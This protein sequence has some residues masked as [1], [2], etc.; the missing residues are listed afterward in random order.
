MRGYGVG[1]ADEPLT[2][3]AVEVIRQ[4][5]ARS[6]RPSGPSGA[7][8]DFVLEDR[9]ARQGLNIGRFV[10][11]DEFRQL[12]LS[13]WEV[14]SGPPRFS[15]VEVHAVHGQRAA[16]ISS[17]IEFG[18]DRV[19]E[20]GVSYVQLDPTL[21][22]LHRWTMFDTAEEAIAELDWLHGRAG[23]EDE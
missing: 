10:G 7:T 8:Q 12:V 22:L 5:M 2:N 16:V 19:S 1:V 15:V 20:G 18:D 13:A 9:S 21:T 6:E 23:D 4:L 3:A 17:R 14:A 11:P